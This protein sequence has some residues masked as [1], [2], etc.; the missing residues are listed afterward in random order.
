MKTIN[1]MLS[2][3]KCL[4]EGWTLRPPTPVDD[5]DVEPELFEPEPVLPGWAETQDGVRS[6]SCKIVLVFF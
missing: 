3:Q 4:D 2:S 5:N 1:Y 6:F